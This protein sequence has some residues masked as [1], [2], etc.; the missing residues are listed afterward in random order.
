MLLLNQKGSKLAMLSGKWVQE[1][2][3]GWTINVEKI[4][5]SGSEFGGVRVWR[6]GP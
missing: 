1:T 4:L 2:S 3:H 5:C 6:A